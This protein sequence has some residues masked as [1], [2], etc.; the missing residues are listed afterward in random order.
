MAV[1]SS[2][3]ARQGRNHHKVRLQSSKWPYTTPDPRAA[4]TLPPASS[5]T[6]ATS[7][8]VQRY[9]PPR[10]RDWAAGSGG[11]KL[12][13]GARK[14]LLAFSRMVIMPPAAPVRSVTVHHRPVASGLHR[15][16]AGG[17]HR[18]GGLGMSRSGLPA[19]ALRASP[20]VRARSDPAPN[21]KVTG[22]CAI[23]LGPGHYLE[24]H[25]RDGGQDA[26]RDPISTL[27]NPRPAR[28]SPPWP[29][30][31]RRPFQ[32]GEVLPIDISRAPCRKA[33]AAARYS[34]WPTTPRTVATSLNRRVQRNLIC[35]CYGQ[36]AGHIA[37]PHAAPPA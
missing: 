23:P 13:P 30:R 12:P 25:H 10:P 37:P 2:P 4:T 35:R 33:S 18:L 11:V 14:R 1:T 9:G 31:A 16:S 20:P 19:A 17:V 28:Y 36:G 6:P 34:C 15:R 32:G 3:A 26:R 8:R 22:T 24:V 21:R 29:E 5:M 27:A 7:F